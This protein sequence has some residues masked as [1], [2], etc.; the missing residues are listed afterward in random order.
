MPGGPGGYPPPS[1]YGP[2]GGGGGSKKGLIIGLTAGG[3]G[4]VLIVIV[5]V[6]VFV[7]MSLG[8]PT[9]KKPAPEM[10]GDLQKVAKTTSTSG[11]S[12]TNPQVDPEKVESGKKELQRR[13]EQAGIKPEG[14]VSAAYKLPPNMKPEQPSQP[15]IPGVDLPE[16]PKR[17]AQV[18]YLGLWGDISD[19]NRAIDFFLMDK[20]TPKPVAGAD[21]D[22]VMKCVDA[23]TSVGTVNIELAQ[24]AWA[25]DGTV[26]MLTAPVNSSELARLALKMRPDLVE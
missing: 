13:L 16:M 23:G 6:G 7:A 1:P 3:G 26:A 14:G 4:L 21:F 10:A 12:G 18:T 20:G 24:C 25:T 22:G 15:S 19:P 9:L 2:Q 5:V 11:P 8:G 17:K